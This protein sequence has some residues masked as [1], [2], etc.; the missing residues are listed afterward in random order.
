MEAKH[1]VLWDGNCGFCRRVACWVRRK[2]R[3]RRFELVQYQEAPSP[4][5]TPAL[6]SACEQALHV[7]TAEGA[8][9]SGGRACLFIL[10]GLG[11]RTL[12]RF[13]AL[14]PFVWGVEFSYRVAAANRRLLSRLRMRKK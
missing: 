11:W 9:L 7:V 3:E 2:D 14:P 12:G 10:E 8:V 1:W 13:L 5:M 6:R 4:P